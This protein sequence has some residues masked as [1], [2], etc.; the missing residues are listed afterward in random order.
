MTVFFTSDTHFG[1]DELR[2]NC[3]R[4]FSN[5]EEMDRALVTNWNAVVRHQDLVYHLGDFAYKTSARLAQ[6]R[7]QLN[8]SI[9]LIRGNHDPKDAAQL[10]SIF[11][12]VHDLISINVQG[13]DIA[14]CHY[15]MMIWE[16][17]QKGAWNLYGH[18]HGSHPDDPL[19]LSLDVGVDCHEYRP[20]SFDEI[21]QIMEKKQRLINESC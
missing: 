3:N 1:H 12:S 5:V 18:S 9:C 6:Y 16:R 15:A 10:N 19:R 7:N 14:L 11:D 21:K 20:L 2:S 4:P 17:S 8:G 13:Q